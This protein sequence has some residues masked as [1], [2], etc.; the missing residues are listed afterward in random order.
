[1]HEISV[2]ILDIIRKKCE[3]MHHYRVG[4]ICEHRER[5]RQLQEA[6]L[7][8]WPEARRSGGVVFF[9]V[10][11]ATSRSFVR[12]LTY[13]DVVVGR[14]RG[15]RFYELYADTS[16]SHIN[17]NIYDEINS[18]VVP[19]RNFMH[20]FTSNVDSLEYDYAFPEHATIKYDNEFEAVRKLVYSYRPDDFTYTEQMEAPDLGEFLPSQELDSFL[21]SLT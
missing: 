16:M 15:N 1:M 19:Y 5:A 11:F 17:N 9:D 20:Q 3:S 8:V 14:A 2:E 10:L 18:M 21:E 7:R 13:S 12:I 6:L 4:I